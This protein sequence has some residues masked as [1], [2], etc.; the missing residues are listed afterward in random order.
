[1]AL[2]LA[3]LDDGNEKFFG[4]R[5]D[6]DDELRLRCARSGTPSATSGTPRSGWRVVAGGVPG[7]RSA[8]RSPTSRRRRCGCAPT[9][10]SARGRS[11]STPP[12]WACGTPSAPPSGRLRRRAVRRRATAWSARARSWNVAFWDGDAGG[13]PGGAGAQGRHHGA[14]A[15]RDD[16]D[17]GC[18]GR[19]ARS[20][21]AELPD[22]LA[23]AAVNS[24][25]PGAADRRAST[26]WCSTS[27]T[28]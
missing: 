3:R 8:T 24:H 16:H 1:M 25:L 27:R 18:R 13:V 4:H 14:A 5:G 20:R 10:T 11:R 17:R 6:V 7:A 22:L 9:P 19:C 28:N 23:A 12:R 26:T 21:R 2:H 15:D